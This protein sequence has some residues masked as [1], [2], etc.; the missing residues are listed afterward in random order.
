[1]E[2]LFQFAFVRCLGTNTAKKWLLDDF[3]DGLAAGKEP[4]FDPEELS[5]LSMRIRSWSILIQ[6][7][8]GPISALR[9]VAQL[10]EPDL[11][12]Q[13]SWL[14]LMSR[15][16]DGALFKWWRPI[17]RNTTIKEQVY[18]P[19]G[20]GQAKTRSFSEIW[21][22]GSDQPLSWKMGKS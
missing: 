5:R 17:I 6:P 2:T 16:T 18:K 1:M 8:R 12:L 20:L 4:R 14:G 3:W 19:V 9:M 10:K 11:S 7:W 21:Q 13:V 22:S 15:V